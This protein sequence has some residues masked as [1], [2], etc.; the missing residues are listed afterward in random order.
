M[1]A[2]SEILQLHDRYS[3]YLVIR[4]CEKMNKYKGLKED[5]RVSI[6]EKEKFCQRHPSFPHFRL[7]AAESENVVVEYK[8]WNFF[9]TLLQKRH[10]SNAPAVAKKA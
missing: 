3:T 1:L 4:L 7:L 9:D 5:G 6:N 10:S 2:T 8:D